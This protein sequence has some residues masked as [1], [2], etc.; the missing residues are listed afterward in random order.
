MSNVENV[1]PKNVKNLENQNH[2]INLTISASILSN[3][4]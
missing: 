4:L 1:K 3:L 2:N